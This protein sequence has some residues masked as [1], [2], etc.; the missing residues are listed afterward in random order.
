VIDEGWVP[1]HVVVA[2]FEAPKILN[3]IIDLQANL[4]VEINSQTRS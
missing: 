2:H 4:V 1:H 3:I